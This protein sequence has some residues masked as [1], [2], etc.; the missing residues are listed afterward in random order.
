[1]I[2]ENKKSMYDEVLAAIRSG[3][4][5]MR[6]K[7]HFALR[8]ALA[9][10]G[11][12]IVFLALLYLVSFIFYMLRLTGAWFTPAFGF[13]GMYA[14]LMSVPWLLVLL[15][16]MFVA[17]LEILV[18]RYAFAYRKPLLYSLAGMLAAVTVGGVVIA[19]TSMHERLF[20]RSQEHR[21]SAGGRLYRMYGMRRLRNIHEGAI[22]GIFPAGF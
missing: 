2:E 16:L 7:W 6:P 21:L 11:G 8:A 18:R 17:I 12:I 19:K 4:V 22:R 9:A 1:M 5:H 3:R 15:S 13:R 10:L 14:S 20:T